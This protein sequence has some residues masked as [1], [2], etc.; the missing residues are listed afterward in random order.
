MR[1]ALI[2][3]EAQGVSFAQTSALLHVGLSEIDL[4]VGDLAK[5]RW[6]L[7]TALA[8]DDHLSVTANHFRWFLAMGRL[9]EAEGDWASAVDLLD[10]A[11]SLYRPGFF[12]DVRPIPAVKARGLIAANQLHGAEGWAAG[13]E[14]SIQDEGDYLA[15]YE[16]LTDVRLRLAQHRAGANPAGLDTSARR[17]EQLLESARSDRRWGSV[18]EI[19][20]LTALTLDAQ[21]DRSAAVDRVS[22]AFTTAPEPGAYARL[23]LAEGDPMH[24]LC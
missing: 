15:E 6:H 17:L 16:C 2:T 9:A 10:R 1:D 19:L 5:A 18:V 23:F 24:V 8:L 4:E 22:E 3:S 7:D 14:W 12:V 13:R 11:Q 20:M 21:G